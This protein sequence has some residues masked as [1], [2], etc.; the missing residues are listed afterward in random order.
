MASWAY[1]LLGPVEVRLDGHALPLPGA[2]QRLLLAMLL[3]NANHIVPAVRV[4]DELWGADL[5]A[6]PRATLRSQVSRLRRALGPA[7]QD[8]AT[9]EGGYRL[10]VPRGRLDCCRFED[11]LAEAA[12]TDGEP[13]LRLLDEALALCRGPTLGEFADRPFALATATRLNELRA[14]AAERRGELLLSLGLPEEAIAALQALLAEHTDREQAR[15]LLMQ[16]LYRVGR[17][18]EALAAFRWWRRHLATELGLDP[19]PALQA[20]EQDILRH[21]AGTPDVRGVA[22]SRTHPLP[23]PVT[24]FVGR[25]EDL[26]AVTGRLDRARLVTLHGPGGVG[27]TRLALEVAERTGGRYRHGVCFCDLAA[28][29]GPDAVTRALAT[30]IGL[31]ERAF[32]RLGDQLVEALTDRHLLVVLDNCERVVPEVAVLAERLLRETREVI[33]LATTRVRLEVDGE[34]VWPVRP[35]SVSGP[36]APAIQLFLDRAHAADPG[37]A[38]QAMDNAELTALCTSLD[39]LPLAIELAAARLPGT[40]VSGL[41][42]NLRDR[43]GLLTVGRRADGRHHS[44]RAVVDWS[45]EQL[46]REQRDLFDRLAVFHGSFDAAAASAAAASRDEP[47]DVTHVLLHL[48]DLSLVTADLDGGTTRY[49]LLE[50]LR[51]YGLQRLAESGQLDAVR[52]GHAGWIADLVEQAERGLRGAGEAGWAATLERYFDDLRAAHA[53][54]TGHD[55]ELSLRMTVQLHW[56]ALWRCQSEVFRWADVSVSATAGSRSPFYAEALASAAFGA[57][58]RGDLD[59]AGTAAHQALAAAQGLAPIGA[60]RPLEA[61][62]EVAVFRGDLADAA[63]FYTKAY[64]LSVS[65]G[66]V[67]DAAWDAVSAAAAYAYGDRPEEASRLAEQAQI[68]AGQCRSPSALAFASWISGEIIADTAPG[69]ARELLLRAIELATSAGSRFV[70]GI[71][72]VSLASLDARHGDVAVALGHYERAIREWQQA[73]AWTPLWVTFR[74]LVE[75]LARA[76]AWADAAT[77]YGAVTAASSGAPPFGADADRLRQLSARLRQRLTDAELRF[78]VGRGE[79]MDGSQ[80]IDF[81]LDA[82]TRAARKC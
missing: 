32:Q 63:D 13:A 73:G 53:W 8:L 82:I 44:L 25:E 76:G 54:L 66:D 37:A 50:T 41:A 12:R 61:L 68:A 39:G 47:A 43:F 49:R 81:A 65:N 55:P 22:V 1:G 56:Y 59:A 80:V 71:A 72:R 2:R 67:L 69:Q 16:A 62:G 28:V 3:V 10:A 36:G 14:A 64:G 30:A 31:N 78:R 79:Q 6:D 23:R 5:P 75:L 70:A 18:T 45:Y 21:T 33:L 34:H 74:T 7:G 27:K 42:G 57:V 29:T 38:Q 20:I 51:S 24:S 15:G 35:L 58:Y 77:L 48:V 26:A 52:A 60:R 11:A 46:T 19:S 17:H 40:T 4:I 9:L